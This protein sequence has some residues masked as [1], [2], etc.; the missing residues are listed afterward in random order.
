LYPD[1]KADDVF[2]RVGP[3]LSDGKLYV[4]FSREVENSEAVRDAFDRGL[5]QLKKSGEY[6]KILETF[7]LGDS[8]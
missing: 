5:R 6:Q 2:K 7:H 8:H 4:G 3:L 1:E